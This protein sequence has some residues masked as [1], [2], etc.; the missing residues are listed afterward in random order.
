MLINNGSLLCERWHGPPAA[1]YSAFL[2]LIIVLEIFPNQY[3]ENVLIF[4]KK[5]A[6]T[7]LQ[8]VHLFTKP[9]ILCSVPGV[10]L[11]RGWQTTVGGLNLDPSVFSVCLF[12]ILLEY[13]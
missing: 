11:T 9:F 1:F 13:S 5:D 6:C 10:F 3:I 2:A 7:I 12:L 8:I 4:F